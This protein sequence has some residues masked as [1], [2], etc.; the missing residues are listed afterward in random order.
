[1]RTELPDDFIDLMELYLEGKLDEPGH[2]RLETLLR[3]NPEALREIARHLEISSALD[4]IAAVDDDF[5]T[6]TSTHVVRIAEEGEFDFVRRVTRRIQRHRIA[7]VLAIAA[8]ITLAAVPFFLRKPPLGVATLVRIHS[9]Q[10]G[11]SSQPVS[12]GS[13]FEEP[14]GLIRLDFHNGAIMAIQGPAKFKVVSA[15][16]LNLISGRL[17]GWCPESAHGF[18]VRT[19]SAALTD[20]GTSFGINTNAAGKSEFLVL[21]GRVEVEK[22]TQKI[23][24]AQGN[25]IAS[26]KE[27]SLKTMPFDASGFRSTWPFANGII[28]TKGALIPADPNVPEEL[29]KLEDDQHVLVIPEK[30]GIPFDQPIQAEITGPGSLAGD[31]DGSTRTIAPVP[32]KRLSS[33]MVRFDPVGELTEPHFIHLSGEVTFD[34]PVLALACQNSALIAGDA[35]FATA[36]WPQHLRGIELS[37]FFNPPD[38]VTLSADRRTV[39]VEFSAGQASDDVRVILEDN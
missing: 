9:D 32:G 37:Q 10:S 28:S 4:R 22:G 23:Q 15:M 3:E 31:F 35:V 6:T 18:K 26:S 39:K 11:F 21:T 7:K 17:N 12:A 13:T 20:L 33:F 24:L 25:A 27:A 2:Q 30:R 34:R 16:E 29:V 5:V 1:M 19:S 14:S 8:A 38:K 36:A